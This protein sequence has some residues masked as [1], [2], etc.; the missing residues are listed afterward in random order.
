MAEE[1]KGYVP[2]NVHSHFSILNSSII[3]KK[4]VER[5]KE[6]GLKELSSY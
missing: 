2:L 5:A 6:F 1:V 3:I 4:L